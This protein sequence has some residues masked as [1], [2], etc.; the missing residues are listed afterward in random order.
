M[1]S[2]PAGNFAHVLALGL[3]LLTGWGR[4]YLLGVR[5]LEHTPCR[6]GMLQCLIIAPG[7]SGQPVSVHRLHP[8][9]LTLRP[10]VTRVL[11]P[12]LVFA[13]PCLQPC[14][15]WRH[16][17]RL[18]VLQHSVQRLNRRW[19]GLQRAAVEQILAEKGVRWNSSW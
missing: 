13:T 6:W 15:A 8:L 11:Q 3:I 10:P 1:E 5:A 7:Q 18:P 17:H 14:T 19:R 12:E 2:E 16:N 9:W 4:G